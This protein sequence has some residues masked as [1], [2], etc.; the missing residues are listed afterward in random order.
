M[1]PKRDVSVLEELIDSILTRPKMWVRTSQE[2]EGAIVVAFTLLVAS[3]CGCELG[4]AV[5][6]VAALQEQIVGRHPTNRYES[7]PLAHDLGNQEGQSL[8][9]LCR[10]G[11]T[12]LARIRELPETQ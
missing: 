4:E 12:L 9:A 1:Q 11:R 8:E 10:N 3:R 2:G 7:L 6:K 5:R